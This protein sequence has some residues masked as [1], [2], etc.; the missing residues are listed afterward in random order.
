MPTLI[1][2]EVN[3]TAAPL[4]EGRNKTAERPVDMAAPDSMS[5]GRS[6][7]WAV[8]IHHPPNH[9]EPLKI[10]FEQKET[11]GTKRK[12]KEKPWFQAGLKLA[13]N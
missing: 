8:P 6:A 2:P 9:R 12:N 10:Q 11:K 3:T 7:V 1:Q 13:A 4:Q 5:T